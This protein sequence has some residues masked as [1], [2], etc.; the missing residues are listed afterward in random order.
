MPAGSPCS[1]VSKGLKEVN[2]FGRDAGHPFLTDTRL[3][4]PPD[5]C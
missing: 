5:F 3:S 4:D 2:G 1:I